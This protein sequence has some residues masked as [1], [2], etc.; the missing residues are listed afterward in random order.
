M[1]APTPTPRSATEWYFRWRGW[2][3]LPL[4][5]A[6]LLLPWRYPNWKACWAVGSAIV[7]SG[8]LFRFWAIRHI[9]KAAR[10]RTEKTRPLILT[11]P[12]AAIRNPL[13]IANIVIAIGFA[14]VACLPWYAPVLALLLFIHYHIVVRCE[15][16]ALLAQH[17]DSYAQF[18][19]EVPRWFPRKLG[20]AVFAKAPHPFAE[21]I[22]REKS[23]IIGVAAALGI[24]AARTWWGLRG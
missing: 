21:A 7:V 18:L 24:L 12:Y 16:S 2:I 4:Y 20:A 9:G 3:P 14:G 22:F 5:V 19:Q 15:E 1:P 6:L 10:T 13:Y 17:G 11:G 23:G 8:C